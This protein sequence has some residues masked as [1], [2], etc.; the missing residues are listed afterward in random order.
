MYRCHRHHN[1][2]LSV[3]VGALVGSSADTARAA[4]YSGNGDTSFGG[5][6]GNGSLSVT[7]N[8]SVLNFQFN[9]GTSGNFNDALVIFIDSKSGGFSTTANFNDR[10]DGLRRAISGVSDSGRS[11]ATFASGFTADYAIALN[12][13]FAGVWQLAAG[14]NNSLGFLTAAGLNPTGNNAASSYTFSVDLNTLGV[15]PNSGSELRF[16]STFISESG[17]RSLESFNSLTGTSG[18]NA[19]SFSEFDSYLTAVPEPTT[20]ALGIFGAVGGL[21]GLMRWRGNKA[22]D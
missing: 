2:L 11:T 20:I 13:G 17:F 8:G 15:V 21:G 6:V 9:R 7:D 16:T 14:D 3:L 18:W 1:W 10:G 12:N 22:K 19:V 4:F 5:A